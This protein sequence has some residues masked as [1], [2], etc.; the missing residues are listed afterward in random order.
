M[1][2]SPKIFLI[3]NMYVLHTTYPTH[4]ILLFELLGEWSE[5]IYILFI[6]K[7]FLGGGHFT[8]VNILRNL[9]KKQVKHWS[10]QSNV[11]LDRPVLLLFLL[12]LL[13]GA[14]WDYTNLL[15]TGNPA[16][17]SLQS[18]HDK[19]TPLFN[20]KWFVGEYLTEFPQ[21]TSRITDNQSMKVIDNL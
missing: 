4:L 20:I 15:S 10:K 6:W 14:K 21:L 7:L 11:N 2:F 8:N 9:H 12:L 13:L 19:F 17:R 18:K 1:V 3:Q 16:G 5:D